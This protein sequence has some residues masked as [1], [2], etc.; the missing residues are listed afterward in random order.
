[1]IGLDTLSSLGLNRQA[2][3]I[4]QS[5][6]DTNGAL[7]Q[8]DFLELMIAQFSNQDPFKPMENGDFL[9]QLAQ[10]GTVSGIEELQASFETVAASLYTDQAM[11][12]SSLI[13]REVLVPG[14]VGVLGEDGSIEGA[15]ELTN[16]VVGVDVRIIDQAGVQVRRVSLPTQEAGL[17]RFEWNGLDESGQ[18]V[19]HGRYRLEAVTAGA[20]VTEEL[21]VLVQ[22]R[23]ESVYLGGAGGVVLDVEG[24]GELGLADV[25]RI[26][27]SNNSN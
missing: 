21:P 15:I 23:V 26:G 16:S 13:D 24:I 18:P 14:S 22:A 1:M 17:A 27:T 12:A 2:D 3:T 20:G 7:Q 4:S 19:A 6:P 8:E 9:G 10:F 25:R 5:T 11:Q